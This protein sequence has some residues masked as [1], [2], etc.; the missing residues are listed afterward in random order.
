MAK[1][2]EFFFDLGSPGAYVAWTQLPNLCK[3]QEAEL[4]YRPVSRTDIFQT[5][6]SAL[7]PPDR[8]NPRQGR[9]LD[10]DLKRFARRYGVP[11]T[12]T[13]HAPADTLHLMRAATGI[14]TRHPNRFK[15]F[16]TAAFTALW[17][18]GMNPRDPATS[19]KTLTAAGFLPDDIPSLLNDAEASAALQHNAVEAVERGV[20]DTPTMFVGKEM[21]FG[22]DRLDFVRDELHLL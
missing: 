7:P 18:E 13:H 12:L 19:E 9:Y 5:T 22:Y 21:F 10:L 3:Y 17:R 20:F 11:F 14:L 15:P 16:V 8:A 1:S 4:V 2:V 6:A